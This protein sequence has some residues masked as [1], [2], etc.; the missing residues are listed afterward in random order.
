MEST[1]MKPSPVNGL[2]VRALIDRYPETW[3]ILQ[4]KII[5]NTCLPQE[6]ES[7]RAARL[8]NNKRRNRQRQKDY[9]S[10]LEGQLRDLKCQGV[11]ATQEVQRSARKVAEDNTRLRALLRHVGV[12]EHVIE[13]W[14]FPDNSTTLRTGC[15]ENW[16]GA[17]NQEVGTG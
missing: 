1:S 16:T 12:A 10:S 6:Q 13:T 14:Q 3:K 9:T 17:A 11:Q 2:D 8:R 5:T 4:S 15:E 7:Q